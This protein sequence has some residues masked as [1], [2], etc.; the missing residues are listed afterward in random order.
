MTQGIPLP[1]VPSREV[2]FCT[3]AE[4]FGKTARVT[5][6][7]TTRGPIFQA[8]ARRD[9]WRCTHAEV[10]RLQHDLSR[11]AFFDVTAQVEAHR[12][13]TEPIPND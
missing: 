3:M 6:T 5:A 11:E 1:R 2:E 8:T 12:A 4:D 10:R 9:L 13:V 7:Y